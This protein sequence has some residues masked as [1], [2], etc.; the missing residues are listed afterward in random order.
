M[1]HDCAEMQAMLDEDVR[2]DDAATVDLA[3]KSTYA[4]AV[5]RGFRLRAILRMQSEFMGLIDQGIVS[6]TRFFTTVLIGRFCDAGE[7]GVFTLAFSLMLA[8]LSAQDSVVLG[9]FVVYC[10]RMKGVRRTAYAGNVAVQAALLAV[11]SILAFSGLSL[12]L[13]IASFSH[14]LAKT[15][16]VLAAVI[17]CVMLHQFGRRVAFAELDLRTAL[18]LDSFQ[19]A[20][21][22]TAVIWLVSIGRISAPNVY[23]VIGLGS[24]LP[25]LVWFIRKRHSFLFRLDNFSK[26]F[27]RNWGLG[28]WMLAAQLASVLNTYFTGWLLALFLNTTAVGI[29]AACA[30]IVC[31]S[32][33]ILLGLNNVFMSRSAIAF[34][35][36][37]PAAVRRVSFR[38]MLLLVGLTGLLVVV[39]AVWGQ[40][41]L[42]LIYGPEYA[43]HYHVITILAVATFFTAASL[44]VTPGLF[45]LE[46]SNLLFF[47]QVVGVVVS[48][49]VTL[50]LM[51]IWGIVGAACGPLIGNAT[52]AA[53]VMA[54]H[55]T[56]TQHISRN[57]G[58]P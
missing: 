49:C 20:A 58:V 1:R 10:N 27:R 6:G 8:A 34:S 25:G 47:G 55:E 42:G 14:P 41:L 36:G 56:L 21:Q 45:S 13:I 51:P 54:A 22:V 3:S 2:V 48:T 19:A 38:A 23:A 9:P 26:D 39:L 24:L 18:V 43:K 52:T 33:P 5:V 46:Q 44:S 15:V 31:L 4:E 30:S 37:G 16:G 12:S 29:Y 11:L 50:T 40:G 57:E 32:N 53:F 28:R 7:L 17:S 35:E